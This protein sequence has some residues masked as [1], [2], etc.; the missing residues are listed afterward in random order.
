MTDITAILGQHP[1]TLLPGTT[2]NRIGQ[3]IRAG[4]NRLACCRTDQPHT[5][6]VEDMDTREVYEVTIARKPA[7]A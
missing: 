1:A 4:D 5:L 2:V 3:A 6:R 7:G